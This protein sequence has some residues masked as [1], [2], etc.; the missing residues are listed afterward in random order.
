MEFPAF[1]IC[2]YGCFF[3]SMRKL[4][5]HLLCTIPSGINISWQVFFSLRQTVP[6]L[7]AFPYETCS[8][9][10]G[11]LLELLSGPE[12]PRTGCSTPKVLWFLCWVERNPQTS[13]HAL[14]NAAQCAA[15]CLCQENTLLAHSQL[16]ASQDSQCFLCNPAKNGS[17][18]SM[19]W[20]PG[21]P[22]S[23]QVFPKSSPSARFSTST[24]W[25]SWACCQ[26]ISP[27]FHGP[28]KTQHKYLVYQPLLPVLHCLSP[29]NSRP[30]LCQEI[31]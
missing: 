5:I 26:S 27:A 28:S 10:H 30:K 8:R 19:C 22:Q 18:P 1:L 2:A 31:R 3:S 11:P 12:K 21:P 6:T 20:C 24:W 17:A 23:A 13:G 15:G 25:T 4:W 9:H 14:P 7:S 16:F 29:Q